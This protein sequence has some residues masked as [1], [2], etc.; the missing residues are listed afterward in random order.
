MNKPII[1]PSSL[2]I[3]KPRFFV[4]VFSQLGGLLLMV[5]PNAI[6]NLVG[7]LLFFQASTAIL[8]PIVST[9][10]NEG[11]PEEQR[12]VI[13]SFE[14]GL[15]SLAMIVLFPLFGLGLTTSTYSVVY[16]GTAIAL[17]VGCIGTYLFVR[18]RSTRLQNTR[19]SS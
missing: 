18:L 2:M 1:E 11:S 19:D 5:A 17:L 12:A 4:C 15:F 13:L 16:S 14:T 7:F 9:R 3:Q 8:Y 10:L 6:I